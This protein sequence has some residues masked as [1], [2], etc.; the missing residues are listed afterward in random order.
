[1]SRELGDSLSFLRDRMFWPGRM[2]LVLLSQVSG[3]ARWGDWVEKRFRTNSFGDDS[4]PHPLRLP[5]IPLG[6]LR[7]CRLLHSILLESPSHGF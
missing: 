7:L 1:M 4:Q 5:L 6:R 2:F 3:S